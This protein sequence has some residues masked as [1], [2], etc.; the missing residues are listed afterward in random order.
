MTA[1]DLPVPPPAGPLGRVRGEPWEDALDDMRAR[2]ELRNLLRTIDLAAQTT[3]DEPAP[4]TTTREWTRL[5]ALLEALTLVA[6]PLP[7]EPIGGLPADAYRA[8][9]VVVRARQQVGVAR[10]MLQAIH[11]RERA[12]SSMGLPR[13][14]LATADLI[15]LQNRPGSQDELQRVRQMHLAWEYDHGKDP[16]GRK[17]SI[18]RLAEATGLGKSTAQKIIR[19]GREAWAGPPTTTPA[20]P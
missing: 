11:R 14:T 20:L 16:D 1:N 13:Y 15:D 18:G 12:A 19:K 7:E 17:W 6:A 3:S 2:P 5:T 9:E 8:P 10:E 4:D